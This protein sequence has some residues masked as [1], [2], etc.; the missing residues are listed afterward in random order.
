M[1][2]LAQFLPIAATLLFASFVIGGIVVRVHYA[3]APGLSALLYPFTV[4]FISGCL[5]GL[6]VLSRLS[7]VESPLLA[8]LAVAF[9]MLNGLG[10][11]LLCHAHLELH[12]VLG[13]RRRLNRPVV[14]LTAAIFVWYAISAA[15]DR[16]GL[17]QAVGLAVMSATGIYAALSAVFV[18][19]KEVRLWP[20]ALAGLRMGVFALVVYPTSLVAERLGVRFPFLDTSRS[21]FEQLYPLYMTVFV[22]LALPAVLSRAKGLLEEPGDSRAVDSLTDREREVALMLRDGRSLKEIAVELSL[23]VP[24]IKSHAGSAYR[25]LGVSGR[26]DLS[27][28][29]L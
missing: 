10:W 3:R 14:T 13:R 1:T 18:L 24:T 6:R 22:S 23:S 29:K 19:R 5:E 26:K 11:F 12:G 28:I 15:F 27:L 25:K 7:G 21:A 2:A 8:D 9:R 16:R 20:S 4:L 17:A